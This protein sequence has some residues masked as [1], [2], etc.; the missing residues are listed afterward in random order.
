MLK[1]K[2]EEILNFVQSRLIKEKKM[3]EEINNKNNNILKNITLYKTLDKLKV[4]FPINN[5]FTHFLSEQ[6]TQTKE[7]TNIKNE[8]SKVLKLKQINFDNNEFK[9]LHQNYNAIDINTLKKHLNLKKKK[10]NKG[11]DFC[12]PFLQE[13]NNYYVNALNE[14][15]TNSIISFYSKAKEIYPSAININEDINPLLF[16]INNLKYPISVVRPLN[17]I[18]KNEFSIKKD[19]ES[20]IYERCINILKEENESIETCCDS[21]NDLNEKTFLCGFNHNIQY[22]LENYLENKIKLIDLNDEE[23]ILFEKGQ[24]L[25]KY[26]FQFIKKTNENIPINKS[27]IIP[28]K[29]LKYSF[30]EPRLMYPLFMNGL[31]DKVNIFNL[32]SNYQNKD[33]IS[34][35]PDLNLIFEK[36]MNRPK[37]MDVNQ[38]FSEFD[39]YNM[40]DNISNGYYLINPPQQSL[41]TKEFNQKTNTLFLPKKLNKDVKSILGFKFN[42]NKYRQK[43]NFLNLLSDKKSQSKKNKVDKKLII[44]NQKTAKNFINSPEQYIIIDNDEMNLDILFDINICAKIFYASEFYDQ[45]QYNGFNSVCDLINNNYLYYNKFII[46]IIDDEKMNKTDITLKCDQIVNSIYQTID[47]KFGFLKNNKYDLNVKVKVVDNPRLINY[48]INQIYEELLNNNYN[49]ETS[50]YNSKYINKILNAM[51]TEDNAIKKENVLKVNINPKIKF[52]L[53]EDY[54]LNLVKTP[55]LREEIQNMINK[56]YSKLNII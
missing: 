51:K 38:I 47:D 37:E 56:K 52:N 50:I 25:K 48:E 55:D 22:D 12:S 4:N 33:I 26:N 23:N 28:D 8:K 10:Y 1:I 46:F 15:I 30:N 21:N 9:H 11:I 31:F 45:F 6:K 14:A 53:Y 41:I 39:K 18:D 36:R 13:R 20:N 3:K 49:N 32:F 17:I 16:K 54:I 44:I 42:F 27:V 43:R 24:Y 29:K 35:T 2:P 7:D 19:K 40:G 5:N 34:N